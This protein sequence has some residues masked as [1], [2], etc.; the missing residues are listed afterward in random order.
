MLNIHTIGK[1][2]DM[3]IEYW[4]QI[5]ITK[6]KKFIQLKNLLRQNIKGNVHKI[7]NLYDCKLTFF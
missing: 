4:L 1:K 2:K 6:F 7:E 3:C 5:K